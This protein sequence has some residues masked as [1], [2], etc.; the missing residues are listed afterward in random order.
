MQAPARNLLLRL[1]VLLV[2]GA[3]FL[4]YLRPSFLLDLANLWLLCM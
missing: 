2:L 1:L 3:T 4:A